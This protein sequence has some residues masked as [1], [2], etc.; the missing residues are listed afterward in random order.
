MLETLCDIARLSFALLIEL[1]DSTD[2]K[3]YGDTAMEIFARL[4]ESEFVTRK[5]RRIED[6]TRNEL[7]PPFS[8]TRSICSRKIEMA[9]LRRRSCDN[10]ADSV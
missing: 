1:P 10:M 8:R 9:K 6:R 7:S 3:H 4:V 5:G 2:G